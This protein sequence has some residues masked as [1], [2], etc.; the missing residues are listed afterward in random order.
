MTNR[1]NVTSIFSYLLST[2]AFC[3]EL[4]CT[5][6]TFSEDAR[7][8]KHVTFTIGHGG[9]G[10]GL[11][12]EEGGYRRGGFGGERPGFGFGGERPG[13]GFGGERPGFGFGGERPGFGGERPHHHHHHHGFGGGFGGGFGH[14]GGFEGGFEGR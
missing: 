2:I 1:S 7:Q 8:G 10:L 12:G 14:G 9:I 11:G 3:S 13:F 5:N 4:L 6:L